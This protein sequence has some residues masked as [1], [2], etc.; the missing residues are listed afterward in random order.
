MIRNSQNSD[1]E[2]VLEIYQQGLDTGE[3]SFEIEAPNWDAWQTKYLPHSRLVW[4]ENGMVQAWAALAPVSGRDCYRGVAEV[5]IYVATGS[6]GQGIGSKLMA[7]GGRD[8][9]AYRPAR[10]SLA[11]YLNPGTAFQKGRRIIS[12][13]RSIPRKSE[14]IPA[15]IDVIPA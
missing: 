9:R 6:L 1:A 15:L 2:A 5:S 4:E 14:V 11:Q 8:S 10:R 7:S 12:K 3:A 13:N